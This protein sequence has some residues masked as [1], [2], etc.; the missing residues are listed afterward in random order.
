MS[1][2][3]NNGEIKGQPLSRGA[4]RKKR[5]RIFV[6]ATIILIMGAWLYGYFTAG[7]DV[8]PLVA[9]ILPEAEYIEKQGELFIG[10]NQA[11]TEIVGFAATAGAP[12]YSGPIEVL[13]GVDAAG[14]VTGVK[15]VEQRETP[16]FFRLVTN[17]GILSQFV[18]R[19]FNAPFQIGEDIDAVSGATLSAEGVAR[20]TRLAIRQIAEGG[21]A[22]PIPPEKQ[23]FKF[24][25][26]DIALLLLFT[27]GYFGHRMRAEFGKKGFAGGRYYPVC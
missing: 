11:R 17:A 7:I 25:G 13:V 6:V 26:P 15:I 27:T 19:E 5:E 9:E 12:G 10:Y 8:T 24:G 21:L 20:A 22:Q 16:G 4:C 23:S 2:K 1:A 18:D 14:T 3:N